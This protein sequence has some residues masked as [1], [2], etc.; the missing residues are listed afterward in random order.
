MNRRF[1]QMSLLNLILA[2]LDLPTLFLLLF[3][4]LFLVFLLVFLL[5]LLYACRIFLAR[6]IFF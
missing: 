3:L 1:T 2:F 6:L 4:L 5:T